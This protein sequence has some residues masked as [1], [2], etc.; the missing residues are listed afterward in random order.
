MQEIAVVVF[1]VVVELPAGE[2]LVHIHVLPLVFQKSWYFKRII[3]IS[4]CICL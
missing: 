1:S 3:S 4:D 2:H